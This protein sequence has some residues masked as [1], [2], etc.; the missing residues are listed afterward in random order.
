VNRDDGDLIRS[1]LHVL[2]LSVTCLFIL[3]SYSFNVRAQL[4]D[5]EVRFSWVDNRACLECNIIRLR[6]ALDGTT[7]FAS[8]VML[9]NYS[10]LDT[11]YNR[12]IQL[13]PSAN[14]RC[15]NH[16]QDQ[17][18]PNSSIRGVNFELC[19]R[20]AHR[21]ENEILLDYQQKISKAY[22]PTIVDLV[23]YATFL[24]NISSPTG[25]CSATLLSA[26]ARYADQPTTVLPATAFREQTCYF[27]SPD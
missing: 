10:D 15:A 18:A 13:D 4:S 5:I 20:L 14:W 1:T 21:S 22:Q 27:V 25:S 17:S 6:L 9:Q 8:S 23:T 2:K 12:A 16:T 3:F 7:L 24:V 19:L 11:H 26:G